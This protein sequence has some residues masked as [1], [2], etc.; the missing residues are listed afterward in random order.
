MRGIT[1]E[2]AGIA[3]ATL[4]NTDASEGK[5]VKVITAP[6]EFGD[7]VASTTF[8]ALAAPTRNYAVVGDFSAPAKLLLGKLVDCDTLPDWILTSWSIKTAFATA[9]TLDVGFDSVP[10]GAVQGRTFALPT[11]IVSAEHKAQILFGAF[12]LAGA[13]CNTTSAS[14]AGTVD[15][16]RSPDAENKAWCVS[17]GKIICTLEVNQA[18]ETEPEITAGAGWITDVPFQKVESDKEYQKWSATLRLELAA[19]TTTT[20]TGA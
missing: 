4:I 13:L 19:V 1:E 17:G 8:G 3:D 7:K 14:Y 20:T 6:N 12:T 18:G 2:Q 9:P 10:T 16:T 11:Q 5:S 15:L